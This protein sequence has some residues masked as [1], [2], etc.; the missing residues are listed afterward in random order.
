MIE[1]VCADVNEHRRRVEQR[2]NDLPG[3]ILP[4]RDEVQRAADEYEPRTDDRLVID[5]TRPLEETVRR[6]LDYLELHVR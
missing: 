6:A 4:T 3:F 5:S 2:A 1:V